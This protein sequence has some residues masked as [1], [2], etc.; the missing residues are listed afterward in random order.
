MVLSEDSLSFPQ[1][2]GIEGLRESRV[3]NS[4]VSTEDYGAFSETF[5]DKINVD[6]LPPI[7]RDVITADE[8]PF[9]ESQ[10][11]A[12]AVLAHR[13]RILSAVL[14]KSQNAALEVSARRS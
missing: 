10:H 12:L 4:D 11:A 8:T 14:L 2:E 6:G 5:S 1:G 9:S 3:G 7:V 13:S